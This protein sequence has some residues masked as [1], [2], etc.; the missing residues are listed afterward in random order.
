MFI[1]RRLYVARSA[2]ARAGGFCTCFACATAAGGSS[3]HSTLPLALL[4]CSY[5]VV[6]AYGLL[7]TAAKGRQAYER[8]AAASLASSGRLPAGPAPLAALP[9]AAAS[10]AA[11]CAAYLPHAHVYAHAA[12]SSI[13]EYQPAA[14]P[15]A[16]AVLDTLLWHSAASIAIPAALINRC[17]A[18]VYVGRVRPTVAGACQGAPAFALPSHAPRPPSCLQHGVGDARAAGA[19]LPGVAPAS[20]RR[21]AG[22]LGR[23]P[24]AHPSGGA[25]HR[26]G[27]HCLV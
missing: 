13:T 6:A 2:A 20:A 15:V 1:S 23:R 26:R 25:P 19:P 9:P 18:F 4:P 7:D 11:A 8:A 21:G 14:V 5:A 10:V 24:G 3:N 16:A 27:G 22:A 17:V 12:A